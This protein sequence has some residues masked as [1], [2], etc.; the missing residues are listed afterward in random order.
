M[1]QVVLGAGV[2][3]LAA[4]LAF[5]LWFSAP[6]TSPE[7]G[8]EIAERSAQG[9]GARVAELVSERS[10]SGLSDVAPR[11]DEESSV[12]ARSGAAARGEFVGTLTIERANGRV[13]SA[14]RGEFA[15]LLLDAEEELVARVRVD[16]RDGRWRAACSAAQAARVAWLGVADVHSEGRALALLAPTRSEP[17]DAML[18]VLAREARPTLLHVVDARTGVELAGVELLSSL[19]EAHRVGR[20]DAL[21]RAAVPV[22]EGLVAE[23]LV[24]EGLVA[25]GLVAEGLSSPIDLAALAGLAQG[26]AALFV[27]APGYAWT[28]IAVE[29]GAGTERRVELELGATLRLL[30]EGD[31]RPEAPVAVVLRRTAAPELRPRQS[32]PLLAPTLLV[33]DGLAAGE[34]TLSAELEQGSGV[35]L[36]LGALTVAVTAGGV[37]DAT[38][39]V[40]PRPTIE[41][42]PLSGVL[43]VPVEWE[44]ESL[45]VEVQALAPLGRDERP[46][47]ELDVDLADGE[48]GD[49]GFDTFRFSHVGLE[50]GRYHLTVRTP[51]FQIELDL[52]PIGLA[53]LRL[54]APPPALLIVR[55]REVQTGAAL[56]PSQLGWFPC[57][58]G[59]PF[60]RRERASY[61]ERLDGYR[62]VTAPGE[63]LLRSDPDDGIELPEPLVR[64]PVGSS[65][66]TLDAARRTEVDIVLLDSGVPQPFPDGWRVTLARAEEQEPLEVVLTASRNLRR[67]QLPAGGRYRIDFD[68]FPGYKPLPTLEF[69]ALHRQRSRIEVE[70]KR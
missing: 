53:D 47:V 64:V 17:A 58:D 29:V 27:G 69:E 22:A 13:D 41:W 32:A 15:L 66:V 20:S 67:A 48:H 8:A 23:G 28:P 26:A 10:E 4:L 44:L 24:A 36:E 56:R 63:V 25:E 70:L 19:G 37:S 31:L 45:Q 7:L 34:Y 14:A 40:A 61:S 21:Q 49:D 62:I 54:V 9:D 51:P 55:L 52:P 68:P 46:C 30:V 2:A 5:V 3:A 12:D 50:V 42:A 16:A 1:K 33:F 65:E 6:R 59:R 43:L 35:A 11:M 57:R 18:A 39:V 60:A 38:L